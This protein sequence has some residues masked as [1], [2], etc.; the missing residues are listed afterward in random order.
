MQAKRLA[1]ERAAHQIGEHDSLR[2]FA[3]VANGEINSSSHSRSPDF[4]SAG[5]SRSPPARPYLRRHRIDDIL[6][7]RAFKTQCFAVRAG[8]R[9]SSSSSSVAKCRKMERV[10]PSLPTLLTARLPRSLEHSSKGIGTDSDRFRAGVGMKTFIGQLG[11]VLRADSPVDQFTEVGDC[12]AG[13]L[14]LVALPR[15]PGA[16]SRKGAAN[17]P[18][19]RRLQS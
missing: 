7:W 4:Q 9:H 14:C 17:L 6:A 8:K 13:A 3:G 19:C 12:G 18:A 15:P 11:D 2:R 16:T 5:S 10:R 1:G